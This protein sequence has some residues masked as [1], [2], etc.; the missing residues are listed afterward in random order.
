MDILN[1]VCTLLYILK[2]KSCSLNRLADVNENQWILHAGTENFVYPPA[3]NRFVMMSK[4]TAKLSHL[5]WLEL[6][7]QN[8][9]LCQEVRKECFLE[10]VGQSLQK[11][12]TVAVSFCKARWSADCSL[13]MLTTFDGLADVLYTI[14][15]LPHNRYCSIHNELPYIFLKMMSAIKGVFRRTTD[16][17]QDS[18]ESTI[19]PVTIFLLRVQEF[20][21]RNGDMVQYLLHSR[22]CKTDPCS[23][24]FDYWVKYL[25]RSATKMFPNKGQSFI[26]ILNNLY[27]VLQK[28][29][30]Q[31]RVPPFVDSQINQYTESY[32]HEC[33]VPVVG[34]LDGETHHLSLVNFTGN[35]RDICRMQ[36]KWKVRTQLKKILRKRIED[37][38]VAKYKIRLDTVQANPRWRW[39]SGL[40][41][42]RARSPKPIAL[43]EVK[44]DIRGLFEL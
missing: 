33:W 25:N 12:G 6:A 36:E 24:I 17:I 14:K 29:W 18:N 42:C 31:Q 19:H 34:Y 13:Q 2:F 4:I 9:Q 39:P 23:Y 11:L 40:K 3:S 43:H 1:S 20:L 5:I 7:G 21:C 22:H 37:L 35:F 26:F 16:A 32:L 30:N 38:V 44:H 27:F 41:V 10:V 28:K 15:D 8:W